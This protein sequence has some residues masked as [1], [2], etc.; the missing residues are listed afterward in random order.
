MD[1]KLVGSKIKAAREINGLTQEQLAAIVGLSPMHIS[2][3]ERGYKSPKLETLVLIA[4]TL[5]VSADYLLGDVI[6]RSS[7]AVLPELSELINTMTA[8]EQ[9]QVLCQLRSYIRRQGLETK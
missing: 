1:T 7:G 2:V 3:L 4:N 9:L 5:N 6:A 8:K